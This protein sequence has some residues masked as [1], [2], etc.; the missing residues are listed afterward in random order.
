MKPLTQLRPFLFRYRLPV[1]A[2][3]A[4][5]YLALII[6]L[7]HH[8]ELR[9]PLPWL[10]RHIGLALEAESVRLDGVAALQVRKLKA[11]N[12]ARVE[13]VEIRWDSP[14]LLLGHINQVTLQGGRLWLGRLQSAFPPNP[15]ISAGNWFSVIIRHLVVRDTALM[16][17]N[18]GPG[19][20]TVPIEIGTVDPMIFND[21]QLGHGLP[22]AANKLQIIDLHNILIASPYDPLAPVMKLKHI[23]LAFSWAGLQQKH[24]DQ[25][26]IDSPT[27]YIGPDLFSFAD[28]L[29]A[30]RSTAAP[31]GP[32]WSVGTVEVIGGRLVL[33]SFSRPGFLLPF[34]FELKTSGLVLKNF[35][36][37]P[38]DRIGFEIPSVNLDYPEI[39]LR[40]HDLKGELF[41]SLPPKDPKAKNLVPAIHIASAE[42]KGLKASNLGV[43]MTFDRQGVFAQFSGEL[44]HGYLDGGFQVHLEDFSWLGWGS[45]SHMELE[46]IT[47]ILTPD[48]FLMQGSVDC[49]FIT[50]GKS[51][52]VDGLGGYVTLEKPG[53]LS[54]NSIDDLLQRLPVDWPTTKRDISHIALQA[55]RDYNYRSGRCDFAYAPPE[56]FLKLSL[57]GLQ[58]ARNF[59]IRWHDKRETPRLGF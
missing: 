45:T 11:G 44:E 48:N 18:L 4:V 50:R 51:K 54:I 28:E 39:G 10:G 36:E 26:V 1:A 37:I 43:S 33:V 32:P 8:I 25:L 19:L 17:D 53:T 55:F 15:K 47:R 58:G 31:E 7:I 40:L 34:V 27:V 16:L 35:S 38:F 56:S 21:I 3:L 5:T 46:N 22:A 9:G 29:Q 42:W 6:S 14:A 12:F 13:Y 24:L 49:R 41:V 23:R 52:D 20:P 57:D 59:D 30:K 2:I